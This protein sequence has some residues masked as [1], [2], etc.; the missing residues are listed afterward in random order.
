MQDNRSFFTQIFTTLMIF[1]LA[2]GASTVAFIYSWPWE[3]ANPEW[4]PHFRLV[5]T[6]GEKKEACGISYGELAEA[7]AKG[8][9]SSL[10]M[11][12]A[13]GEFEEPLNWLKWSR[14]DGTYE[15]KASS[16]HFQSSIRYKIEKDAPVLV[17]VQ[18]VDVAKA[19]IYGMG[20]AMFLVI[21]LNLRRLRR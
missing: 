6:C 3:K 11:T 20:A 13:A 12:E 14:N 16:W 5:A 15:V 19:F 8:Q 1:S 7:K 10:E 21:G 17:A 2:V 4:K 9:I 18:D